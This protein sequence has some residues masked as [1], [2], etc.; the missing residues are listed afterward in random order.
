[1]NGVRTIDEQN[2]Q[3]EFGIARQTF[4]R[5]GAANDLRCLKSLTKAKSQNPTP[6]T[7]RELQV[8]RLIASGATNR[9]IAKKL[10]ISEKTVARH[11]S[12]MFMKL[13]LYSRSAAVAYAYEHGLV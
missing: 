8:L 4:E 5:L 1:M 2:A 9:V 13:N 3:L 6:L 7:G 11:I 12:N 10:S